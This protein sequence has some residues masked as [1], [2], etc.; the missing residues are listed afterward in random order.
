M[1]LSASAQTSLTDNSMSNDPYKVSEYKLSN[2]LTVYFSSNNNTPRLQTM[3]AI[4]AGSKYD[5]ANTTGLAHYLEHMMFKGTH[6]Y[7]SVDWAKEKV[8][9]EQIS[10]LYED[11]LNEKDPTKKKEIYK[12]I[13]AMS[14]EASKLAIPSEYDKMVASIGA[15]GTN[16]FTSNDMTVYINDI[17]STAIEK[18]AKLEA[19]RFSTLVLRLFH[20]ELETV[21]EEF[22]R[23]QDEDIR[24][25]NFAI[26]SMLMPNHPYGT[27]TTIGVGEHLKNPSM[28]NIHKYFDE[29]YVPNNAA[30]IL[31]GD[32]DPKTALPILEKYFGS[33][34]KRVVPSFEKKA[35]AE[36]TKPQTA[37]IYGPTKEHVY[38]GYRFEGDNSKDA[39]M[40]TLVDM[41]LSNGSTGLLELNLIQKQKVLTATS[42]VNKLKDYSVFKLYA[43]PKSG[44]TLEEV[45][46]SLL[47]Q[48]E[49]IKEGKFDDDL[50]P[51]IFTNL[52][53]DKLKSVENNRSRAYAI[54]D[55]FVK[56][57]AWK[58]RVNQISEMEKITKSELV[59][60]AKKHFTSN[61]AVCYKKIGTPNR[62]KVD[63]PNIT[64]V[65]LN[66]DFSS[67]F[68]NNFDEL[69]QNNIEP[70]FLD[71]NTA[72][73]RRALDNAGEFLYVKNE[74][75]PLATVKFV[76]NI[77]TDHDP[78]LSLAANYS[79][80][81]GS[82]KVSPEQLKKELF[83]LGI[84]YNI[85]VGR[86]KLNLSFSGLEENIDK[87]LKLILSV[88][89]EL[90]PQKEVFNNMIG[91]IIKQRNN[92]KLNKNVILTQAMMNYLKYGSD[93][94]FKNFLSEE[95]LKRQD[96]SQLTELLKNV[97]CL[98][99]RVTYH[100]QVTF[101]E[102]FN[103]IQN[104]IK[105]LPAE[106]KKP[107]PKLFSEMALDK[108]VVYFTHYN[109]RQA[110][111]I[112][113]AKSMRY[114]NSWLPYINLYNDYY[115]AGL[116]S[117][118]F[119]EV[120]EKMALAYA[121]SSRISVPE[122]KDESH[123][124]TSYIGTQSDKLETATNKMKD[125][126]NNFIE[127]SKQFDGA[128]TSIIR[129]IESDWIS[130]QE[131]INAFE[132]AE[133][134]GESMDLRQDI[135]KIIN[136]ISLQELKSYF[137]DNLSKR[138]QSY[139]LIGDRETIDFESLK[140]LGEVKILTLEEL[141]GY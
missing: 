58:D 81:L 59:D 15:S 13:D 32:V 33:W 55:A 22:N 106:Y 45:K 112:M 127:V 122:K 120:R 56:D 141:F 74:D 53:L 137:N 123:Y 107:E 109:M 40:A 129:N 10:K 95:E 39:M 7:G 34:K 24:W 89:R 44:Q 1:N 116:S 135:Y 26:D 131:V 97:I 124:L 14:F 86:E 102:A 121:V 2:G 54:M 103:T 82:K 113:L 16:A 68:K 23:S 52:K 76:Y 128:K 47:S 6:L 100:G 114:N 69:S 49:L 80:Y 90:E 87:A 138:K 9:L 136:N 98:P 38:I 134:R 60:F 19:E 42:Y 111:I 4:K 50:L 99:D 28:I 51:A 25:S 46:T 88:V 21:Y 12:K 117:I 83:K 110:E 57:I 27:Q 30:I 65:Q 125:L 93:N 105:S 92:A 126:L 20:T 96:P 85:S 29:Y 37:E 139:V 132:R 36:L 64:P 66:K 63:K 91:D 62:H 70:K 17:P 84:S 5:P 67:T 94:P 35:P 48:I 118:M 104:N 78:R 18:W 119:Q 133:K 140:K 3:I 72:I 73:K 61:Y 101:E 31:S 8:L 41:I 71:F 115:G 43:E 77:G 108:P 130:G 11:H 79:N 75:A